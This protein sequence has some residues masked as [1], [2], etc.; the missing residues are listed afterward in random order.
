M[1]LFTKRLRDEIIALRKSIDAFRDQAERHHQEDQTQRSQT[2]QVPLW[3]GGEVHATVH[4]TK[5]AD[6]RTRENTNLWF[7]GMLTVGAWL[8]F[9]AT[10][11]A[12]GAAAYYAHWARLTFE[13]IQRQTPKITE[14]AD[15]AM[16]AAN[17]SKSVLEGTDAATITIVRIE[18][19][20]AGNFK[21]TVAN[22]GKLATGDLQGSFRI[23]LI[24][25]PAERTV[26]TVG[27][28]IFGPTTLFPETPSEEPDFRGAFKISDFDKHTPEVDDIKES[29]RITGV[30]TFDN[31][32]GDARTQTACQQVV[33]Q[34]ATPSIRYTWVDC[35]RAPEFI[36]DYK[37]LTGKK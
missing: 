23:N 13:E 3:V 4:K 10:A 24:S 6:D 19:F 31:G 16:K 32:F 28:F 26:K 12:F 33:P 1:D 29:F 7:Q 8:T 25:L 22:R 17:L 11:A 35:S 18:D 9:L 36:R 27:Q 21:M 2:Q 14:S 30:F 37:R 34:V 15:A 5:A 20:G